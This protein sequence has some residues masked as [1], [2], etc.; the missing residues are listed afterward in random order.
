MPG[1]FLATALP[2][3]ATVDRRKVPPSD[4]RSRTVGEND[5]ESAIRSMPS[6]LA[7]LV[8]TPCQILD[9]LVRQP[10]RDELGRSDLTGHVGRILVSR[11]SSSLYGC[12]TRTAGSKS[13]GECGAP[14]SRCLE[15]ESRMLGRMVRF[16]SSTPCKAAHIVLTALSR[17]VQRTHRR[18]HRST[19]RTREDIV[20]KI[21]HKRLAK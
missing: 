5:P 4:R 15:L 17:R 11:S 19:R 13:A 9:R 1:F 16:D 8:A 2:G 3:A 14:T 20:A 10:A 21:L 12:A 18:E 7:S 6:T